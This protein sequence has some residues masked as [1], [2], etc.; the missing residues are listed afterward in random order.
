MYVPTDCTEL[1]LSGLLKLVKQTAKVIVDR[2]IHIII[3]KYDD[4]YNYIKIYM[5][6]TWITTVRKDVHMHTHV[7]THAPHIY[8]QVHICKPDLISNIAFVIP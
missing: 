7:R 5:L 1:K 8:F 3:Y 2:I 6:Y 4:S